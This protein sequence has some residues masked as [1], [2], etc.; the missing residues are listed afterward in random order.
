MP[1]FA[2]VDWGSFENADF[3]AVRRVIGM[4]ADGE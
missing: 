4:N 2:N 1:E 3:Y